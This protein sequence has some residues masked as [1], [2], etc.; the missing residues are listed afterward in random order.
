[1]FE[2]HVN[3]E[4]CITQDE[5]GADPGVSGRRVEKLKSQRRGDAAELELLGR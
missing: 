5:P 1:M 4:S 2:P 3:P